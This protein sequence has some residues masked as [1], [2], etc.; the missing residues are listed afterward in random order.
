MIPEYT[1]E[2]ELLYC[3]SFR[4]IT[5]KINFQLPVYHI[6]CRLIAKHHGFDI[7]ELLL[8]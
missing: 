6:F 7:C 8:S 5:I 2:S 3:I 4:L 1:M